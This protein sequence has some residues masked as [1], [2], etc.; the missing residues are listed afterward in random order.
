MKDKNPFTTAV[1]HNVENELQEQ[2]SVTSTFDEQTFIELF[3]DVPRL[4]FD[5]NDALCEDDPTA[6]YRMAWRFDDDKNPTKVVIDIDVAKKEHMFN[7]R[8]VRNQYLQ[9]WDEPHRIAEWK[10]DTKLV[11]EISKSKQKLRDIPNGLKKDLAAAKSV[12]DV[13]AVRP[14]DLPVNAPPGALEAPLMM[15][16]TMDD[17]GGSLL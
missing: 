3:G 2:L 5:I 10:N 6:Q 13:Q 11:D 4:V 14:T 7:I 8:T 9:W 1:V 16:S 15:R 12:S 17:D